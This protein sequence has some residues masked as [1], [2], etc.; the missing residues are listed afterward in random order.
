MRGKIRAAVL[1]VAV[2]AGLFSAM[3]AAAVVLQTSGNVGP[4]VKA[5]GGGTIGHDDDIHSDNIKLL[6][7]SAFEADKGLPA[8]GSDLAFQ[9]KTVIAG[10]YQGTGFFKILSQRDGFIKQ[11]G[12]HQC[13]GS[14]G[15]VSVRGNLLFVSI[16]AAASNIVENASCNNTKTNRSDSSLGKEGVRIVDISNLQQPKQVAFIET[17]CGSHT[18]TLLPD[19]DTTYVYVESYPISGQGPNC[20]Q[21]T[22]RKISII[23]VPNDAPEKAELVGTDTGFLPPD[24]V[25]CH[26]VTYYP[27]R[28]L[29]IAA[30]LGVWLTLDV[31]DPAKPVILSETRNQEIEL[32]HSSAITWDGNIALIGDEHAGAAGGGGCS[33]DSDSPVGAMWFYDISGD[34]VKNPKLLARHSLPRVPPFNNDEADRSRCTTHNFNVLPMKD[35]K[36]YIVVSSYYA[37]GIAAIDFSDVQNG[38][39][40]EI[41]HYIHIPNG[42]LPDTWS[43]YWYNGRIYANNHLGGHGLEV[44]KL[45]GTGRKKVNFFKGDTNPQVQ[46]PNFR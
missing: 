22:H 11:I 9:G 38:N 44:F 23:K 2:L 41:G 12:F 40:E 8:Q 20:N 1:A 29:A 45:K 4:T 17:D 39:V 35:P 32:D 27:Q 30:C 15:D 34:N 36:K 42:V 31:S 5:V 6:K 43:S 26:D 37:G 13:P 21:L 19:G 16:D 3:P 14:Q 24:T 28:D 10:S 46:I 18:N 25:G 33:P 7:R